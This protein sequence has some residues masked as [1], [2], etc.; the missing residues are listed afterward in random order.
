MRYFVPMTT[1]DLETRLNR[2]VPGLV[3]VHEMPREL[4][5]EGCEQ[6]GYLGGLPVTL[7]GGE[8]SIDACTD[9]VDRVLPAEFGEYVDSPAPVEIDVELYRLAPALL[10]AA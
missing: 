6:C 7:T 10:S 4:A 8:L 2:L 5:D 3:R 1:A 9:C